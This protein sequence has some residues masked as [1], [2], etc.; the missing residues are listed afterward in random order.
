MVCK[1][2]ETNV[3]NR[4]LNAELAGLKTKEPMLAGQQESVAELS[5]VVLDNPAKPYSEVVKTAKDLFRDNNLCK[6]SIDHIRPGPKGKTIVVCSSESD[7]TRVLESLK[8]QKDLGAREAKEC[9]RTLLIKNVPI[10]IKDTCFVS[11]AIA[12]DYHLTEENFTLLRS[13]KIGGGDKQNIVLCTSEG[14]FLY[15][16]SHPFVYFEY[17]R[18]RI[19]PYISVKQC[20]NC[21]AFGHFASTCRAT[22]K[23]CPG[24]SGNHSYKKCKTE[25]PKCGLCSKSSNENITHKTSNISPLT[26]I[27]FNKLASR[28]AH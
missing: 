28:Y 14:A 22:T 26:K 1:L 27:E 15:L 18:F 3:E 7:K 23:R 21:F 19:V 13:F 5:V 25:S 16:K 2:A 9:K 24:C 17:E 10:S 4:K 8:L 11:K 12:N 20:F 6:D